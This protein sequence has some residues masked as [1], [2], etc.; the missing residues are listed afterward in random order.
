MDRSQKWN[1]DQKAA[2]A[3]KNDSMHAKF[4]NYWNHV[5]PES[6]G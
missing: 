6:S 2:D 4:R 1:V 3:R 5:I